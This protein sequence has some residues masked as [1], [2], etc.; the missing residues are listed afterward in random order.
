MALL[1]I[2]PLAIGLF[3]GEERVEVAVRL[4][5]AADEVDQAVG[6]RLELLIGLEDQRIGHGLEPLGDVAVLKHHA[7]KLAGLLAGRNAEI[8]NGMALFRARH[9]V[10]ENRLLIGNHHIGDKLLHGAPETVVHL[11]VPHIGR[12]KLFFHFHLDKASFSLYSI[13]VDCSRRTPP[14]PFL[15]GSASTGSCRAPGA[16]RKRSAPPG[17][18][19]RAST[20]RAPSCPPRR[21]IRRRREARRSRRQG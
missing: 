11:H 20:R 14:Q 5:G 1:Q 13:S 17:P 21:S 10:V 3:H 8:L 19:P 15:S 2:R 4:L 16:P 9:L 6:F 7:V 18:D 12:V